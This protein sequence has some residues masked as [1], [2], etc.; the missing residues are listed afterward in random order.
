[1]TAGT[2]TLR[3]RGGLAMPHPH[4]EAAMRVALAAMTVSCRASAILAP[5]ATYKP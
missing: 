2:F 1:M 4:R 3:G 5:A